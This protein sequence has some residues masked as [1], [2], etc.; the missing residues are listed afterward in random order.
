MD[1]KK[2]PVPV[3]A[4]GFSVSSGMIVSVAA[5]AAAPTGRAAALVVP[6][7]VDALAHDGEE[8]RRNKQADEDGRD[9]SSA[10]F[11]YELSTSWGRPSPP[12]LCMGRQD[13]RVSPAGSVDRWATSHRDVAAPHPP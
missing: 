1:G 5:S 6:A 11:L 7:V 12:S 4:G 9:H 2:P 8:G 10:A 13:L 3:G